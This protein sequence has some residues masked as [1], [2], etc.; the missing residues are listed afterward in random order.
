MARR[1]RWPTAEGLDSNDET[2]LHLP[3]RSAMLVIGAVKAMRPPGRGTPRHYAGASP[4]GRETR[5]PPARVAGR[6]RRRRAGR[7]RGPAGDGGGGPRGPPGLARGTRRAGPGLPRGARRDPPGVSRDGRGQ[8]R[9][10]R[11]CRRL[12]RPGPA[13]RPGAEDA[14]GL[15][16]P[17]VPGTRVTEAEARPPARRSRPARVPA[18]LASRLDPGPAP[19]SARIRKACCDGHVADVQAIMRRTIAG[20]I[21]ATE[22]RRRADARKVLRARS[23]NGSTPDV[24]ASWTPP[25]GLLQAMIVETKID[26]HVSQ[27]WQGIRPAVHGRARRPTSRPA[28]AP[29]WSTPTTASWS[30][31]GW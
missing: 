11:L 6:G 5:P 21:C 28:A 25:A 27:R 30:G 13:R 1:T 4:P 20:D 31:T 7:G 26:P 12:R 24:P 29:S 8:R 19:R 23:R 2:S 15:P 17:I 10:G 9:R 3:G 14:D 22:D 18:R 16:V